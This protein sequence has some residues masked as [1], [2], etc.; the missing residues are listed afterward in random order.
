V[1]RTVC[2]PIRAD[3]A[4]DWRILRSEKLHDFSPQTSGGK[5]D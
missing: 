5:S 2:L 4:G 1:L 3:V